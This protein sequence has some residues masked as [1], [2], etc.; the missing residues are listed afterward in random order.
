MKKTQKSKSTVPKHVHELNVKKTAITLGTFAALLHAVWVVVV[1]LGFGQAVTNWKL[2]MHFISLPVTVTQF[3]AVSA[4]LLVVMAFIGGAVA[5]A[6]FAKIWN[7][8][9]E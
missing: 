4:I 5:G 7:K 3:D 8:I 6:M 2:S 1:A 9:Q